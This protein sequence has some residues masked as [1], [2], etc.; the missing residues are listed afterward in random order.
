MA[1][2]IKGKSGQL[3]AIKDGKKAFIKCEIDD[4]LPALIASNCLVL[5]LIAFI[6]W[7]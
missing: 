5:P 6:T 3:K 4:F 7:R 1:I 2:E